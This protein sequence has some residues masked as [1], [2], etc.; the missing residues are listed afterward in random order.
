MGSAVRLKDSPP[1]PL[2]NGLGPCLTRDMNT[3]TTTALK[4][5]DVVAHI[6]PTR[7]GQ[8]KIVKVNGDTLTVTNVH[9]HGSRTYV[10]ASSYR[11]VEK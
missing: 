1:N 5:G 10:A 8:F 4:A 2:P 6:D 11:K 7:R 9:T 3:E